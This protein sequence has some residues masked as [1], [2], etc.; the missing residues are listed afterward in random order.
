MHVHN[1]VL[2]V[3]VPKDNDNFVANLD[4]LTVNT[5]NTE[6]I[7]LTT[8]TPSPL[9]NWSSFVAK[10]IPS[11][12]TSQTDNVQIIFNEDGSAT[13]KPPTEF[14]ANARKL[15][16]TSLIG[17]FIGGSFDFKFIRD[18][19][20]K[21]W[22][23]RM[24]ANKFKKNVIE[25]VPCWVKF[26]EVPHSYWSREGLTFLAKAV[27]IP[28][29]FD[30]N[31]ARFE[32]LRFAS[33]QVPLSYSSPRPDFILVP[34][35]DEL[36]NSELVKVSIVYPQLPYSCS[37]CKAFGH[38]FS[39][40]ANNPNATKPTPRNRPSG[41]TQEK[42]KV[43][44]QAVNTKGKEPVLNDHNEH[45]EQ[46]EQ[47][48]NPV[49]QQVGDFNPVIV[50]E[51]LGCDV[52]LD[53]DQNLEDVLNGDDLEN[54]ETGLINR[55]GENFTD[56]PDTAIVETGIT[57]N[58]TVVTE[59]AG[60]VEPSKVRAETIESSCL[61][62]VGSKTVHFGTL[63]KLCTD[64]ELHKS[65]VNQKRRRGRNQDVVLAPVVS[66]TTN[67]TPTRAVV[68]A[69]SASA[70]FP[71]KSKAVVDEDGFTQHLSALDLIGDFNCITSVNEVCGGRE[72][73]TPEMQT[74]KDWLFDSGPS[75]MRTVGDRF[76][77]FN[78]R[79]QAPIHKRLDRMLANASWFNTFS[80]GYVMVKNGGLMDHNPLLFEEPMQLQKHGK[81]FQ[82]F[83]YMIEIPGFLDL[84][85]SAWSLNCQGSPMAHFSAKLKHTKFLIKKLNRDHGHIQSNVMVARN[86]LTEFQESAC[87]STDSGVLDA[88]KILISN[89]N[90][91]LMQEESFLL[92][93][94]RV[95]WLHLGDSNNSFFHQQIKVSWN[96]NKVLTLVDGEDHL[97]HGQNQCAQVAVNY[98]SQL[99]GSPCQQ[100]LMDLSSVNCKEL[101]E[102][103][104]R[105]LTA[106]VTDLLI[107]DIVKRM[108]RNKAPGP[109][110]VN[111]EFFY[112]YLAYH[113]HQLL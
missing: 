55:V 11:T 60:D 44:R 6:P 94:A 101:N 68:I 43:P 57:S 111:V 17:H 1:G 42:T 45:N 27:G 16:N 110:S 56:V 30:E 65:P 96:R 69:L 75:S 102:D 62:V 23:I 32:P 113:G 38:S 91:A 83:N 14:L 82:F 49:E 15:W 112:C 81:P 98:F 33:V 4:I 20:F 8:Q 108:K 63:E 9:R 84:V 25:T 100:E 86:T 50:D 34:V 52:V 58:K 73:W 40:C 39:R 66:Q 72:C 90:N 22:K 105:V 2:T 54:F 107:Y 35:E 104:S 106:P 26:E 21:L 47:I 41:V 71:P 95:K 89:L 76:T 87:S 80:E 36:G 103:Q 67:T 31:T 61:P 77:W 13:L 10:N 51:F 59:L 74:F 7:V 97:V 92:Q 19:A 5:I 46:S 29:K 99:L 64:S 12:G 18:H 48:V 88:E 109:D 24:E 53:D 70:P 37:S 93:K 79:S 3:F 78:K 85:S 28:L